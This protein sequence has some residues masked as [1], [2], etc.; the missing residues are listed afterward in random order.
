MTVRR[1]AVS[2]FSSARVMSRPATTTWP[3]VSC[4]RPAAQCSRVDLPEPDGPITAVQ[5][6]AGKDTETLSSA[7]TA[8]SWDP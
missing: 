1:S 6:P 3:E 5:E 8:V 7:R 2:S 4:S